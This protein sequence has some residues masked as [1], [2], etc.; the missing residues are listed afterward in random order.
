MKIS[1]LIVTRKWSPDAHCF[2]YF[3][4]LKHYNIDF[5][6]LVAEGNNPSSQRN[7]L[8]KGALGDFILFLD[9]D[10]IPSMSLL[11]TYYDAIKIHP[12]TEIIG[13]PSVLTGKENLLYQLSSIFFSSAFGIGPI[14]SRYNSIGRIRKASERD[15]ILCNLLMK[16]DFFLKTKGFNHNLY[17]GEENEFLKNLKENTNIIYNPNAI[18]YREPRESV[19]LFLRQMFSYGKGRSKH[20]QLNYLFEYL[21]LIPLFFSLYV[22]SLPFLWN[23]SLLFY[24]PLLAHI[25]LTLLTSKRYS[26]AKF[27][28][29]QYLALPFFFFLGHFSYGGGILFGL[30][31]YKIFKKFTKNAHQSE[32]IQIHK[33]KSFKKNY[34]L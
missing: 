5:E 14:R 26:G 3:N 16:K 19:Y 33:L 8:A 22:L 30:G 23:D 10:S 11:E 32:N 15:L 9:D 6:V 18:V 21:F 31:K 1:I 27:T 20:L 34:T 13:G 7:L 28:I 4:E 17:P 25:S 24:T 12:D 2:N 29:K